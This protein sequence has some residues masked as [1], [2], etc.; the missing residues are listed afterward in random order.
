MIRIGNCVVQ[1]QGPPLIKKN[2]VLS[3]KKR[4]G[5]HYQVLIS[6]EATAKRSF[7]LPPAS[8]LHASST[9]VE[10]PVQMKV[11]SSL[12]PYSLFQATASRIE[13]V[14]LAVKLLTQNF[15]APWQPPWQKR[16]R[17]RRRQ[18]GNPTPRARR[19]RSQTRLKRWS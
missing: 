6:S 4:M 12:V 17:S 10:A 9:V 2:D 14:V 8:G 13:V 15:A 3:S 11:P 5:G 1:N 19:Q 16:H 7:C 18:R